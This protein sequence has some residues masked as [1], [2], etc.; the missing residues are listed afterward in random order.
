VG[1]R[2]GSILLVAPDGLLA[3]ADARRLSSTANPP[4]R[5]TRSQHDVAE[6]GPSPSCS[7]AIMCG[8]EIFGELVAAEVADDVQYDPG[9]ERVR[10]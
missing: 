2:S 4:S 3:L 1:S 6:H 9:N 10:S 5:L 8:V 7:P